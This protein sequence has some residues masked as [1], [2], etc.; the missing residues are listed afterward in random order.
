[1]IVNKLSIFIYNYTPNI[2]HYINC[3]Y[4]TCVYYIQIF[5]SW[6]WYCLQLRV[7]LLFFLYLVSVHG[8]SFAKNPEENEG[9]SKA[10]ERLKIEELKAHVVAV[11]NET[12]DTEKV[13]QSEFEEQNALADEVYELTYEVKQNFFE[14]TQPI[15]EEQKK[16]LLKEV[17]EKAADLESAEAR[18]RKWLKNF[19]MLIEH[20]KLLID[21]KKQRVS[22]SCYQLQQIIRENPTCL[23]QAEENVRKKKSEILRQEGALKVLEAKLEKAQNTQESHEEKNSD[24]M[25]QVVQLE[26]LLYKQDGGDDSSDDGGVNPSDDFVS[27]SDDEMPP[28]EGDEDTE[29]VQQ[30]SESH[31]GGPQEHQVNQALST[32]PQ[33]QQEGASSQPGCSSRTHGYSSSS[34]DSSQGGGSGM[35]TLIPG[36]NIHSQTSSLQGLQCVLLSAVEQVVDNLRALTLKAVN[37]S[38]E[39]KFNVASFSHRTSKK[40]TFP[41]KPFPVN[42]PTSKQE[43]DNRINPSLKKFH[44]FTAM[45]NYSMNLERKVRSGQLGII[46]NIFSDLSIGL[47]YEHNNSSSKEHVG[48]IW[49][50]GIGSAK[51]TMN[52]NALSA[53]FIWDTGKTGLSGCIASY[54]GW[55]QMKNARQYLHTEETISSK[56]SPDIILGGGLIQLGYNCFISKS[57]MITPYIEYLFITTGWKEYDEIAGSLPSHISST[58]EKLISKNIGIRNRINLT[59]RSQL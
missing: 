25:E 5:R 44:V 51:A 55:G 27:L 9:E 17:D 54:Y 40:N 26:N 6:F 47:A 11:V 30:P 56:G 12:V 28:L 7:G 39:N 31:S 32:T 15:S 14:M 1:M 33:E 59:E 29:E 24:I 20:R 53:I 21:Q 18:A 23:P 50:S 19:N 10:R 38:K 34:P 57:V 35:S 16:E 52:T 45:D 46:T 58:K 43:V 4:H 8:L 2:R 3:I 37:T 48:A 41:Q 36:Y 49:G 22:E 13:I 42:V